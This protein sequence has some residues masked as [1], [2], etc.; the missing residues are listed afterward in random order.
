MFNQK[1]I[2]RRICR[3]WTR[4]GVLSTKEWS[5]VQARSASSGRS[6]ESTLLTFTHITEEQWLTALQK[7]LGCRLWEG[8]ALQQYVLTHPT[9]QVLP[10]ECVQKYQ[11]VLLHWY[12]KKG[13]LHIVMPRLPSERLLSYIKQQLPVQTLHFELGTSQA[14]RSVLQPYDET[15]VRAS[16]VSTSKEHSTSALGETWT[17]SAFDAPTIRQRKSTPSGQKEQTFALVPMHNVSI[18]VVE[19]SHSEPVAYTGDG[20]TEYEPPLAPYSVPSSDHSYFPPEE[21]ETLENEP[22]PSAITTNEEPHTPQETYTALSS[23]N[24]DFLALPSSNVDEFT[25]PVSSSIADIEDDEFFLDYSTVKTS[26]EHD[27]LESEDW[28]KALH[29]RTSTKQ[30][31]SDIVVLTETVQAIQ[32][33]SK[34]HPAMDESFLIPKSPTKQRPESNLKTPVS[35]VESTSQNKPEPPPSIFGDMLLSVDQETSTNQNPSGLASLSYRPPTKPVI[36]RPSAS[37]SNP[38]TQPPKRQASIKQGKKVQK[39][40]LQH[41]LGNLIKLMNTAIFLGFLGVVGYLIWVYVLN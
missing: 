17:N 12:S 13:I 36:R 18:S 32:S 21:L 40:A 1:E 33:E 3:T 24:E 7:E 35:S 11:I 2:V 6:L 30:N 38:R 8:S 5:L 41:I 28:E 9:P 23:S 16:S 26:S 10:L 22:E 25:D 34:P 27:E 31:A 20:P 4:K 19:T 29:P 15:S 37:H 14:I 39:W